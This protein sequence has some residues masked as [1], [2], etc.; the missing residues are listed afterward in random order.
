[1][2]NIVEYASRHE[3]GLLTLLSAEPD[4]YEFTRA[5]AVEHFKSALAQSETLVCEIEGEVCA[6]LRAINDA[7]GVYVSELYV[8]PEFRNQGH[9]RALLCALKERFAG[10]RVYVLSDEDPYYERLGSGKGWINLPVELIRTY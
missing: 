1:M 3:S 10:N 6:Y 4:W 5:S 7:F 8:A 2:N 9:A